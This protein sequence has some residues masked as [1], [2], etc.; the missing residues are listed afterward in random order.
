MCFCFWRYLVL[1]A[2]SGDTG[3]AVAHGFRAL[4]SFGDVCVMVLYPE[5][6]VSA[7]Q[8]AQMLSAQSQYVET[9]GTLSAA[10]TPRLEILLWFMRID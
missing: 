2:T 9:I 8:K 6:G 7:I 1:A 5:Q 4:T 10:P 3:S